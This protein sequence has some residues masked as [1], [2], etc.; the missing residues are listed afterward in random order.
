M[1]KQI[2]NCVERNKSELP[3]MYHLPVFARVE[4]VCDP[5]ITPALGE[6]FRPRY[7]V[8]LVV[9]DENDKPDVLFPLFQAV[10]LPISCAGLER[11]VFGFPEA[12]TIVELA[13][14]YGLPSKPFIR[15]VLGDGLSMPNV[16]PGELVLQNGPEV[17]Q[18]A[19]R[20]GNWS[21]ETFASI[22]DRAL[23]HAIESYNAVVDAHIHHVKVRQHSTEEI[24]GIKLIEALGALK[25]MSGGALHIG[26]VGEIKMVSAT[27]LKIKTV[28]DVIQRIGNIADSFAVTKQLIKVK[29]GGTVWLGSEGENVLQI[30]SELIQVVED[31][32]NTAKDH[33]HE[34]TDNGTPLNTKKP[35]QSGDFGSEKS[36][37]NGLKTRLDP[38][39][40]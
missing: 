20:H 12:G 21:R 15:T 37:A 32:A 5:I 10:P 40:E 19:D 39:V 9:L 17:R 29:D 3:S 34:Y 11:G 22:T 36:A 24:T 35:N 30:L 7:A 27:N 6:Q 38:I 2:S 1:D 28:G 16:M 13:F 14:A 31:I 18:H 23:N 8:D 33:T 25:L 26:A 4:K